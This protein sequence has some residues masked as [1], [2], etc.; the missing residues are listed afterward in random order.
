MKRQFLNSKTNQTIT[1]NSDNNVQINT[2]EQSL[3]GFF[4]DLIRENI[5]WKNASIVR[6]EDGVEIFQNELVYYVTPQLGAFVAYGTELN[7]DLIKKL[8]EF[9]GN[10]VKYFAGEQNLRNYIT[11]N[12]TTFVTDDKI[13]MRPGEKVWAFDKRDNTI[14][15]FIVH[16]GSKR[17]KNF[18]Y[19]SNEYSVKAVKNATVSYRKTKAYSQ[20]DIEKVFAPGGPIS[21]PKE[22]K[23]K[24]KAFLQFV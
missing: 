9:F 20:E 10:R 3:A 17:S 14:F 5:N 2:K 13:T 1:I 23:D 8:N 7:S 22:A 4:T 24:L 19:Y 6:T 21:I 12:T 11:K 15:T 16:P 18:V